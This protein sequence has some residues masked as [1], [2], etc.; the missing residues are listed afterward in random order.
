MKFWVINVLI[1]IDQFFNALLGPVLN[2]VFRIDGFGYADETISSV[3]GKNYNK[4]KLCR[5]VCKFLAIF[6]EKHCR[7]AI[8]YDEGV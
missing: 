8:E 6:Q 2:L 3:L 7:K 1:A 5:L 4:C